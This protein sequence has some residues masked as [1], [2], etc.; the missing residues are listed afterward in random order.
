MKLHLIQQEIIDIESQWNKVK[1]YRIASGDGYND[2]INHHEDHSVNN[3]NSL[4]NKVIDNDIY[5]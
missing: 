4:K 1:R 5:W 3:L 2:M